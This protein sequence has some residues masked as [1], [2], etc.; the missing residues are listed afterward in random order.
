[1][2]DT[3]QLISD[4]SKDLK[5]QSVFSA[6]PVLW[7]VGVLGFLILLGFI[8]VFL[9]FRQSWGFSAVLKTSVFIFLSL[10]LGIL[11]HRKS[12]LLKMGVAKVMAVFFT[13]A[14]TFYIFLYLSVMNLTLAEVIA[15]PTFLGCISFIAGFG[16]I[17]FLFL[18]FILVRA[19][20]EKARVFS[21][22]L[23]ALSA[24]L[25]ATAYS[26]SCS[27]DSASYVFIAYGAGLL[28]V[29]LLGYLFPRKTW[30]W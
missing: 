2:K 3:K 1:M 8:G 22:S 16:S 30:T 18:R 7:I 12:V 27:I 15:K 26:L 25:A 19:R 14:A 6:S 20:P 23:G 9:Y 24:S 13:L 4:L 29:V 5:P 17:I 28:L 21:A 10:G 11:V